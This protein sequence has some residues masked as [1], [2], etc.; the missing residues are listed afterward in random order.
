MRFDTLD[1]LRGI[2]AILVLFYH[3]GGNSPVVAPAGYLAVDL[4][5]GLSGFVLS[6]AYLD[7][8]RNGL[9]LREFAVLRL[10]RVYPMALIGAAIGVILSQKFV[11]SLL[12][13]PD[14]GGAG[15]LYP[16]N[17]PLWSLALE[18][19]VNIAFAVAALRI[20]P[21]GLALILLSSGLALAFGIAAHGAGALGPFWNTIGYGLVRTIFSFTLGVVF[22]CFHNRLEIRRHRTRKAWLLAVAL[23]LLL[24]QIPGGQP[25]W[26]MVCIFGLLPV[27]L[28]LGTIWE[29]PTAGPFRILGEISFPLYCIHGVIVQAVN[30]VGTPP[31]YL[32]IVLIA[33]AW[34]LGSRVDRPARQWLLQRWTRRR[35]SLEPVPLR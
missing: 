25:M 6:H 24:T 9:A 3:L 32:W 26:D 28:W 17:V 29:T 7:R 30:G 23:F 15:A 31:A 21:R 11:P 13:I 5:F 20:G 14:F 18:L 27:L 8:L 33:A 1:G 2:A 19:L 34:W 12:L 22:Q 16:A 4:F 10:I 35:P